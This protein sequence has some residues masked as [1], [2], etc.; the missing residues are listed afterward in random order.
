[1]VKID[2]MSIE[3][4]NQVEAMIDMMMKQD[5]VYKMIEKMD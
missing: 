4:G 3:W 1:M 2:E 5:N